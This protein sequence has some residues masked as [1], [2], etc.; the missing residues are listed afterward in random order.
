LGVGPGPEQK[1]FDHIKSALTSAPVLKM[2]YT[3][4]DFTVV[5]DASAAEWHWGCSDA[6]RA[7]SGLLE[8]AV[9]S[10]PAELYRNGT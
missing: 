5:C 6:G 3:A 1:A 7:P 10:S 9:K 8:Q 2:P 4:V